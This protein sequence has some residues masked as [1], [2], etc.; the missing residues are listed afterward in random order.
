MHNVS[1]LKRSHL[2]LAG[3]IESNP[4]PTTGNRTPKGRPKKR[5]FSDNLTPKRLKLDT[6]NISDIK[7]WSETCPTPNLVSKFDSNHDI[8]SKVSLYRGDI[9]KLEV[10]AIVNAANEELLGGGGIDGAIHKAAGPKLREECKTISEQLPG[11]RC[12][13]GECKVTK[14]YELPAN[15]VFHTVGP[16]DQNGT[17]LRHCYEN[18]LKNLTCLYQLR[19]LWKE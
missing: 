2:L 10:D 11:V 7:L 6:V 8:N 12:L 16:R 4:D 14:G 13:T 5:N 3:D 18:C 15:R 17:K 9:T 19:K 1:F